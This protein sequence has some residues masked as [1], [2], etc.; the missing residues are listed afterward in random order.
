MN[1]VLGQRK[2]TFKLPIAEWVISPVDIQT[3]QICIV[4]QFNST[5]SINI[6]VKYD[7]EMNKKRNTNKQTNKQAI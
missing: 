4:V 2:I 5:N 6:K 7:L 1:G 3:N